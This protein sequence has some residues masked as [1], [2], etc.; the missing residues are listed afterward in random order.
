LLAVIMGDVTS[1]VVSRSAE[2]RAI[3]DF[4]ASVNSQPAGL[5]L[6]GD[7]GIG[8]TT[9]WLAAQEHARR[10]G[11]TLL[12]AR[13]WEA[14]SVLAYGTVADLLGD[15]DAEVLASLP[16]VQQVAVNRL[17]SRD[18]GDGP[19]T[20]QHVVSAALLTIVETLGNE[21]PVLIAIDDLQWLDPSSQTVVS[22]WPGG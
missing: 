6:E 7:A 18:G 15:V 4:C 22:S 16:E 2:F 21:A 10:R 13:A 8:K 11:F 1:G 12:S 14:D 17:L 5:L 9:L 20:D 3:A 19:P